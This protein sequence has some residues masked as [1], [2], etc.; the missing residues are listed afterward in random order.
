MAFAGRTPT[1]AESRWMSRVQAC[2]CIVCRLYMGVETPAEIHHLYGK[3]AEDCHFWILPLCYWHHRSG[4]YDDMVVSRHP[5]KAAFEDCYGSELYLVT[6]VIEFIDF[7][8][9]ECLCLIDT[10]SFAWRLPN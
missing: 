8:I 5:N 2:G 10:T 7:E 4:R 3:T 1:V 6:K 9:P